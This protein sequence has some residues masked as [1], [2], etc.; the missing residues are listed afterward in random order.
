MGNVQRAVEGRVILLITESLP[1]ANCFL[2]RFIRVLMGLSMRNFY[3]SVSPVSFTSSTIN[4]FFSLTLI[5]MEEMISV[6][7]FLTAPPR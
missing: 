2:V 5:L 6:F 7:S 3:L 1:V 4:T